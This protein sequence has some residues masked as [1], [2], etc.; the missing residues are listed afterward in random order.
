MLDSIN[1]KYRIF[2]CSG[3]VKINDDI[4]VFSNRKNAIRIFSKSNVYNLIY[5]YVL[6]NLVN[7]GKLLKLRK[8]CLV[9]SNK[10]MCEYS[11]RILFLYRI[12]EF[13]LLRKRGSDDIYVLN[14]GTNRFLRNYF[15]C[16]FNITEFNILSYINDCLSS[17]D[18]RYNFNVIFYD[19]GS[20]LNISLDNLC[21]VEDIIANYGNAREVAKLILSDDSVLLDKFI[22][23]ILKLYYESNNICSVKNSNKYMLRVCSYCGNRADVFT[24]HRERVCLN[25]LKVAYMSSGILI[26]EE[27]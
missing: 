23:R 5:R 24:I 14:V 7:A 4:F 1:N 8:S 6:E 18:V 25:C 21:C 27:V 11:K 16:N 2:D 15:R 10:Y 12:F 3:Y 13:N 17:L 22:C 19:D 20:M 9:S 26:N